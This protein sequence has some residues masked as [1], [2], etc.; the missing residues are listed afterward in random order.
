MDHGHRITRDVA[1]YLPHVLNPKNTRIIEYATSLPAD[2]MSLN[3]D[4]DQERVAPFL[5]RAQLVGPDGT[6]VRVTAQVDDGAARN[7]ISFKRWKDYGHCLSPLMPSPRA[8][9][10]ANGGRIWPQ[11]RWFGEVSVGG[12][13]V[14]G[15]FEVFPCNEAFDIILGKP[16]LHSVRA[17]HDYETDEIRIRTR[18]QETRIQ[19]EDKAV[20]EMQEEAEMAE[21]K[22]AETV[23]R[24]EEMARIAR[25]TEKERNRKTAQL[26]RRA[27][28]PLPF[29]GL[30][31]S[32]LPYTEPKPRSPRP[33]PGEPPQ[34][35][36]PAP[37]DGAARNIEKQQSEEERPNDRSEEEQLEDEWERI[38][39]I[40]MS[41]TPWAETRF[42]KYLSVDP[43]PETD[44]P[45]IDEDEEPM[46]DGP[47]ELDSRQIEKRARQRANRLWNDTLAKAVRD[48]TEIPINSAPPT[49]TASAQRRQSDA[50]YRA[51]WKLHQ[52]AKALGNMLQVN[53]GPVGSETELKSL[54]TLRNTCQTVAEQT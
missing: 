50:V 28:Q 38:N 15:W 52:Q 31:H 30:G 25:K 22:S 2:I 45:E 40:R 26:L 19:N 46:Q 23:W 21:E 49:Q 7:C 17:I 9:G 1:R 51:R 39:L 44:T 54:V 41:D 6:I 24:E 10:V 18:G 20:I 47:Q 36:P 33:F 11:G 43:L 5:Q 29:P 35:S 16:W 8:L 27:E 48:N 34:Q 3:N 14:T 13:Q 32:P 12:V 42:A 53:I 4:K 37:I